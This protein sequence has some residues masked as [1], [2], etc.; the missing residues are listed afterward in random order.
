MWRPVAGRWQQP[1]AF[2]FLELNVVSLV[3]SLSQ[4][5]FEQS[6]H[7]DVYRT[8]VVFLTGL[9]PLTL[10]IRWIHE[11]WASRRNI[12]FCGAKNLKKLLRPL[13]NAKS[14]LLSAKKKKTLV[15]GLVEAPKQILFYS[16]FTFRL[17]WNL[18]EVFR[19][20]AKRSKDLLLFLTKKIKK[21]I[22]L[23]LFFKGGGFL[24]PING[25]YGP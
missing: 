11:S 12:D 15:T 20:T 10:F 24:F 17:S 8:I 1:L 7:R 19:D 23:I 25:I 14:Q 16:L 4:L 3:F 5:N 2:F 13:P 18:F 22:F 21:N 9:I 6:L